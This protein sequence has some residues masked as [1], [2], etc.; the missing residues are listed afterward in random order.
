MKGNKNTT[1]VLILCMLEFFFFL[2][3]NLISKE[4]ICHFSVGL[5]PLCPLCDLPTSWTAYLFTFILLFAEACKVN[6][7]DISQLLPLS[8]LPQDQEDPLSVMLQPF[9]YP[10]EE[11]GQ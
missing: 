9:T 1:P 5:W 10:H 8:L 11:E 6:H 3:V 2:N 4:R 7:Y